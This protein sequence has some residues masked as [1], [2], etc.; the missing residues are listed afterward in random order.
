MRQ[1]CGGRLSKNRMRSPG[2][3]AG[4]P[5]LARLVMETTSHKTFRLTFES[6]SLAHGFY[7][8]V[9]GFF[10]KPYQGA[11]KEGV[12]GFAKGCGKGLTG[13]VAEPVSGELTSHLEHPPPSLPITHLAT[14]ALNRCLWCIWVRRRRN[15]E[16]PG[17]R[18]ARENKETHPG[19]E[20]RRSGGFEAEAT[21]RE[22]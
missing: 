4:L 5:L 8:G 20:K 11:K 17:S 14:H 19:R 12:L 9:G 7:D 21:H 2:G 10:Y 6:Q 13:I 1:G 3:R 15:L 18:R 16:K 22:G